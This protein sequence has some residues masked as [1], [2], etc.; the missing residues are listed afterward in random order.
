MQSVVSKTKPFFIGVEMVVILTLIEWPIWFKSDGK[1]LFFVLYLTTLL[2]GCAV[3]IWKPARATLGDLGFRPRF[4]LPDLGG[5]L[6]LG[7]STAI[8]ITL[9]I[10][11]DRV[12]TLFG[13]SKKILA[14]FPWA[15]VQQ[16]ILLGY[17]GWRLEF[18]SISNRSRVF[19]V[20]TLFMLIHAP[21]PL[22]MGVTIFGGVL[23]GI[24][25]YR[26]RNLYVL[27]FAHSIIGAAVNYLPN[28][29]HHHLTIGPR[30]FQ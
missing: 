29:W 17:F 15:L 7:I 13:F 2:I 23:A 16:T 4:W 5:I 14:Y 9:G 22:L 24:Y 18:L 27:S 21:N 28:E 26:L 12:P 25:F 19:I 3:F 6:L 1:F 10:F 11:D 30:F 8:L 20:A